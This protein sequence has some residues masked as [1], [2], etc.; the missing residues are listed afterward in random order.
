MSGTWS[1]FLVY[2]RVGVYYILK[3]DF[4]DFPSGHMLIAAKK[5]N[6]LVASYKQSRN[7]V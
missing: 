1:T 7:N 2:C 4:T 5:C 3:H 6:Q